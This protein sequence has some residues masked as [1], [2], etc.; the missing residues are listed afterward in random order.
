MII[1]LTSKSA[2][3][4]PFLAASLAAC[5]GGAGKSVSLVDKIEERGT[6]N[7][8]GSQGV[9]WL[10]RPDE[11]VVWRGFDSDICR[12]M[13]AAMLGD[14]QKVK[15]VP[16]NAAKRLLTF[17]RE[18]AVRFVA[19]TLHDANV[20]ITLKANGIDA[21]RAKSVVFRTTSNRYRDFAASDVQA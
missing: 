19:N 5:S 14:A 1:A 20:T 3:F 18:M 2:A 10:S 11:K 17:S 9:P 6:L 15:F 21:D 4:A 8:S 7:Y 13:T 12:S 16:L